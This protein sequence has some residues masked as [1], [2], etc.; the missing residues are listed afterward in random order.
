MTA[1]RRSSG[2]P[3][4]GTADAAEPQVVVCAGGGGVGKTTTAA[5]LGLALARRGRRA[6]VVT[7][8]PARRLA[9]ALGIP[10]ADV[11]TPVALPDAGGRLWALMPDPRR[12]LRTFVGQLFADEPAAE[13]RVLA[14]GVY[15][16]LADAAAGVHEL[17]TMNLVAR[18][19]A[20]DTFD[21][22]V[23]DTAPSRHALDALDYPRRLAALL[24]GRAVAWLA[25]LAPRGPGA[26]APSR[27]PTGRLLAWG[28]GRVERLVGRATG[29]GLARDTAALFSDLALV[30][31]RFA[32]LARR[33][34][35]LLLGERAGFLLV[36]DSAVAARDDAVFLA[37]RLG[38]QGRTPQA[39]VLNRADVRAPPHDAVLRELP[40]A[41]PALLAALD[42]LDRERTTRTAAADAQARELATRLRGVP[43]VR[44]PFLEATTPDAVVVGLAAELEPKLGT[45]VPTDR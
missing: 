18:A 38:R 1:P 16:G 34:S 28:A 6:L 19:A 45:L 13:T 17:V 35:G 5:A 20:G 30:R 15:R 12:S 25:A 10:V 44:L 11:P 37:G 31:E 40:D 36:A 3:P 41:P 43:L 27:T 24:G 33:A 4:A 26:E 32:A 22:V 42:T 29:P 23:I 2:A 14:N 7:M 21:V 39:L 9:G 8:D